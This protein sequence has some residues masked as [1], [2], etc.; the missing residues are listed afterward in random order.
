MARI[1][2]DRGQSH[3]PESLDKPEA[4]LQEA[5]RLSSTD[6][7][8]VGPKRNN[9]RSRTLTRRGV[10]WLGQTCNLRCHFCYFLDRIEN[11]EHIEHPF[12]T[13][14]KAKAICRTLRDFYGNTA[15]DIQ[16][17]EPT[18]HPDILELIGYCK[19]IGLYP[20]LITNALVLANKDRCR[21]F[22]EAG[23][24]DFLISVQ[25]LGP[26]HDAAVGLEGAH[27][28][29]MR[30]IVNLRELGIPFRFNCV[31]S[32]LATPQ[33]PAI[34]ALAVARGARAVNFLTFNP[35]EDQLN[36]G[37]RTDENVPL[38]SEV[39]G[40]L[41]EALD[42]LDDAGIEANVRYFP[43]CL[44]EERHRK[45]MY[46]FKQ[47]PYDHHEW[48]YASW[49][50]TGMQPQRSKPGDITPPTQLE[51]RVNTGRLSG[52]VAPLKDFIYSRPFLNGIA[53]RTYSA[54]SK[55][56]GSGMGEEQLYWTNGELRAVEH[57]RYTYAKACHSCD[58]KNICDG[59]HGDYAE[60]FG[61]SEARSIGD[62]GIV[63][64]PAH[65]IRKQDKLVEPEDES[66]ALNVHH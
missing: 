64:H 49:T 9:T 43:M 66:W 60:M 31:L 63:E 54:V 36:A 19:G 26:A 35:F 52:L 37:V 12:M 34:A 62:A 50:W 55:L 38:Y 58:L 61:T 42:V 2:V 53:Q 22:L 40:P 57:C 24:R 56:L 51:P 3:I 16:G 7:P 46:N 47:L 8:P 65:F 1:V 11:A 15:I 17:G 27:A 4:L 5:L 23:V 29:Q 33:L 48:D 6:T 44:V 18:L 30:A 14:D 28:K 45:S 13:L 10:M 59:F 32:K 25:G 39:S 20:T 21:E 41:N